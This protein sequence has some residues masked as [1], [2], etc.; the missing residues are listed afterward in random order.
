[1]LFSF[2]LSHAPRISQHHKDQLV[3]GVPIIST[4][5][6]LFLALSHLYKKPMRTQP[7]RSLTLLTRRNEIAMGARLVAASALSQNVVM[8][9]VR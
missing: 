2:L 5:D 6:F 1:M 9:W 7:K 3:I 8:L 4:T